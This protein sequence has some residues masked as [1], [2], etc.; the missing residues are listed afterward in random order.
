MSDANKILTVSYGTFSC[1][2]E[3]FDEPFHAMKAIAEYFRDLAAEDR[4]FGAEPPT[5]DTEMLHRITEAAIQRRVEARMMETGLLLRQHGETETVPE[6]AAAPAGTPAPVPPVAA[7]DTPAVAE[8]AES[9]AEAPEAGAPEQD[10]LAETDDQPEAEAEVETQ[11]TDRAEPEQ[12]TAHESDD[13]DTVAEAAEEAIAGE[14]AAQG[15]DADKDEKQDDSVTA[16]EDTAVLETTEDTIAA[17]EAPSEEFASEE[18]AEEAM[19]SGAPDAPRDDADADPNASI[20]AP[21]GVDTLAAIAAALAEDRIDETEAQDDT[22][23]ADT[24]DADNAAFFATAEGDEPSIDDDSYFGSAMPLD[25]VSVAERLSRI[26]RASTSAAEI[27]DAEV[28]Q[29]DG[30]TT[31]EAASAEPDAEPDVAPHVAEPVADT[32]DDAEAEAEH[33]ASITAAVAAEATKADDEAEFEAEA[34]ADT[35]TPA[36]TSAVE[37]A[38]DAFEDAF[39]DEDSELDEAALAAISATIRGDD[40]AT[41]RAEQTVRDAVG[42]G[43]IALL[44]KT[45]EAD[46]LF[47]ATESRLAHADTTRRRANIEHL[48]AA[49]AARS[50]ERQLAPEV[51]DESKDATAEYRE[52]LAH[53]MRPRRV[54]VDVT[55]RRSEAR[56]A[57]L[58]LISE[59]RVDADED[60]PRREDPVRPRRIAGGEATTPLRLADTGSETAQEAATSKQRPVANSLALLAQRASMMMSLG[61]GSSAAEAVAEDLDVPTQPQPAPPTLRAAP[62]PSEPQAAEASVAPETVPSPAPEHADAGSSFSHSDRFALRL[63]ASDA[64]EIEEVVDLAARYAHEAFG[65]GTFDRPELF[66]MISEATDNSIDREEMLQA[67]GSLIRKG[68]IERVARGAFRVVGLRDPD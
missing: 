46:R 12:E 58:V 60:Q 7:E 17:P 2:L 63:E 9:E 52:D 38:D 62:E 20:D 41:P 32:D 10:T 36:V 24:D 18:F 23:V 57:P 44:T 51:D 14:A 3:G 49:V 66:R 40:V 56:P 39:E 48:K 43:D 67:F 5:P 61:R 22:A 26:R 65:A 19:A 6:P 68:K 13:P 31:G 50:A 8:A 29:D 11:D 16:P 37:A 54:R 45:D 53:V 64:V 4:Y 25:G 47:D 1:T 42:A 59:Q 30:E 33:D 35:G 55:R 27:E 21:E 15:D 34:E 28:A